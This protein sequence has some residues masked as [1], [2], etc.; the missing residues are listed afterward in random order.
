MAIK[1]IA[2]YPPG[3]PKEVEEMLSKAVADVLKRILTPEQKELLITQL[4]E[5]IAKEGVL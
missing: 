1:V 2:N 4:E 5:K 3:G